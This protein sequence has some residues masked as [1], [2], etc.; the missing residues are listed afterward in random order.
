M[1]T[2]TTLALTMILAV[3]VTGLAAGDAAAGK[4]VFLKKC[5]SCHGQGGEG[6]D[7]IAQMLKVKFKH[8]G[9]ADVQAKSDADLKKVVSDGTGKMKGIKDIEAKGLDDV[10][11]FVRTL[12]AK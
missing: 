8:L 6:K 1:K 5:A 3:P 4:D 11:A 7:T 12:K 10:L 9:A 2:L